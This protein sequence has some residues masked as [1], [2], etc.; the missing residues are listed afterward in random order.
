MNP[1][2][3]TK[4]TMSNYLKSSFSWLMFSK[5]AAQIEE[6]AIHRCS[7]LSKH[8]TVL[9]RCFIN[10]SF[11]DFLQDSNYTSCNSK[12]KFGYTFYAGATRARLWLLQ[13][14]HFFQVSWTETCLVVLYIF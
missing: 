11:T 7:F 14:A 8:I 10:T 9:S 4:I 3:D 12:M 2:L 13:A 1:K 5:V 6:A